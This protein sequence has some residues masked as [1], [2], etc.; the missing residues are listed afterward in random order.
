MHSTS[1]PPGLKYCFLLGFIISFLNTATGQEQ[2]W[3]LKKS[4]DGILVYFR[5]SVDSK[6]NELKIETTVDASIVSVV[7]LMRDVPAYPD[8]VMNCKMAEKIEACPENTNCYYS[9]VDFPWPLSDRD[10][11]AR[12]QLK[13][14]PQTMVVVS[15]LTADPDFLPE[16]KGFVRIPKMEITWILTPIA[17]DQVKIDYHLISDPGGKLPSWLI[18]LAI[19]KGPVTSI[20]RFKEMV[21]RKQYQEAVVPNIRNISETTRYYTE[22]EK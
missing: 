9:Q 1:I 14:D 5:K 12:N 16:Q 2:D 13:Q 20:K 7:A 17:P 8:W 4:E 11:F 22:E 18:N 10:F 21:Q 3:A 15:K 19:D 6:I